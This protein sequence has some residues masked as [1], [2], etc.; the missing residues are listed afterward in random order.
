MMQAIGAWGNSN[1]KA[2]GTGQIE[3][4]LFSIEKVGL[5]IGLEG[6]VG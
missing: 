1:I 5:A 3:D 4:F 2:I 6:P